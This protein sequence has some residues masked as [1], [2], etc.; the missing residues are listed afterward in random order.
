[1]AFV[2]Y[3]VNLENDNLFYSILLPTKNRSQLVDVAIRSIL[4]QDFT[5]LEIIICD[6]DDTDATGQVVGKYED[7]RVKYIRTGGLS[8]IENWTQAL[9]HASGE[10]VTVLEDKMLMYPNSLSKIKSR[11]EQSPSGVVVWQTDILEDGTQPQLLKQ[12]AGSGETI[13]ESDHVF[14]LLSENISEYWTALPRGLSSIVP[15]SLILEIENRTGKPFYEPVSL[16]L[17]SALKVLNS[18]DSYL[19]VKEAYSLFFSRNASTGRMFKKGNRAALSYY[20]GSEKSDIQCVYVPVNNPFIIANSVINDYRSVTATMGGKIE[21]HRIRKEVYFQLMLKDLYRS[22]TRQKFSHW[23][24]KNVFELIGSNSTPVSNLLLMSKILLSKARDKVL[25][26][27][28]DTGYP[29]DREALLVK[30]TLITTLTNDS[31][32]SVEEFLSGARD[33]GT[34]KCFDKSLVVKNAGHGVF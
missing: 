28:T 29:V 2:R 34:I 26:K 23:T 1:M 33:M 17:V 15:R 4:Q 8:M 30:K 16:D 20:S 3:G 22:L 14:G 13:V 9:G 18:I 10:Y 5:D 21:T 19:G 24:L 12:V 6:N 11:I 31:S 25:S 7:S 27:S 32:A